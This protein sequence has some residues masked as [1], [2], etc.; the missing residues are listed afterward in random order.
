MHLLNSILG[1]FLQDFHA[2]TQSIIAQTTEQ[3]GHI[4]HEQSHIQH[5]QSHIQLPNLCKYG[6]GQKLQEL[7]GVAGLLS[8]SYFCWPGTYSVFDDKF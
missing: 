1:T 6:I 5:T 4:L 8:S 7:V 3:N 2:K